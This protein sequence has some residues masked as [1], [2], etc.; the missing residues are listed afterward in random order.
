MNLNKREDPCDSVRDSSDIQ[1][2][3]MK[4]HMGKGEREH[5]GEDNQLNYTFP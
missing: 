2:L 4:E 3:S 5:L 1:T